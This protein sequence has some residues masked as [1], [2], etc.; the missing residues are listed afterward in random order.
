MRRKDH[1]GVPADVRAEA[2]Q[3][4]GAT[5]L[6]KLLTRRRFA[7]VLMLAAWMAGSGL[8]KAWAQVD[9]RYPDRLI[10]I[11]VPLPAGGTMDALS[12]VVG[13]KL[14]ASMGQPVIVENKPGASGGIGASAVAQAKPDGYTLLFAIASTI[15]SISLQKAPPF[16]LSELEPITQLAELPTGFAV[17]RDLGANTLAD[18]I[19]LAKAKPK[20]LSFGSFGSGSTG[21]IVGE[22]LAAAAKVEMVHVPYKGEAPAITDLLG[23]H[24]S[25]A[26][27]SIGSL[28]QQSG[29]VKLLAITGSHRLKQFPDVPTF[30]ELG[31][32]LYGLTGWAGVFAPAGTP[33]VIVDKLATEI[34][35]IVRS[36]DVQARILDSGFEPMGD[37]PQPF[38]TFVSDQVEKW[39]AAAKAAGLEPE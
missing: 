26:F 9:A 15:Q 28:G 22:G 13:E 12:R 19:A 14:S 38:A 17:R 25:S 29:T 20:T 27:A 30:Q 1:C 6:S 3:G 7:I 2:G 10:K 33:K 8:D 37:T 35:R 18:F 36:P 32:P 11:I 34:G 31:F 24:I 23:G 4:P 39:A 5:C 16:K 21:H